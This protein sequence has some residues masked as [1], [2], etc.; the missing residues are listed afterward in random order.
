MRYEHLVQINDLEQ[1]A[2]PVLGREQLWLGLAARAER[3]AWFDPSIDS[4]REL[5]RADGRFEHELRRGPVATRERT[6]V[7]AGESLTIAVGGGSGYEG[8]S[9]A[10]T[11]EEPAPRALFL[12]FVYELRG[13]SVPEDEGERRA[14]R[15]AYYHAD[16]EFVRRLREIADQVLPAD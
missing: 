1:P 5:A 13:P 16:L 2:L 3:P 11:I 12:R 6:T 9:L 14:L 15:Q 7:A 8:S 4:S 10:I